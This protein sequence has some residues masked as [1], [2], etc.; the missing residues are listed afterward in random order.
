M[1]GRFGSGA[2]PDSSLRT[3][4]QPSSAK[5]GAGR[6]IRMPNTP[7]KLRT[8]R[9]GL[10]ATKG[11]VGEIKAETKGDAYPGPSNPKRNGQPFLRHLRRAPETMDGPEETG[12]RSSV[13]ESIF[14]V[15]GGPSPSVL[16]HP[17]HYYL[18]ERIYGGHP[19][20]H[21]RSGKDF[22][23]RLLVR[24]HRHPDPTREPLGD[25]GEVR[26]QDHLFEDLPH[27]Q[28]LLDEEFPRDLRVEGAEV[29]FVDEQR[30][31]ATERA[32]DLR[33]RREFPGDRES[34]GGVDLR[35]L[36]A[37]EFCDVV[38][39]S[40][41][42]LDEDADSVAPAL[43]VRL[44][45]DPTEPAVRELGQVLRRLDLE[46]RQELIDRVH[47]DAP[48]VEHAIHEDIVDLEFPAERLS[49]PLRVLQ[50]L[51][52]GF[53]TRNLFPQRRGLPLEEVPRLPLRIEF[54]LQGLDPRL[55]ATECLL[56]RSESRKFRFEGR[57]LG[58]ERVPLHREVREPRARLADLPQED[59]EFVEPLP[60]PGLFHD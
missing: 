24:G 10:A 39:L 57:S 44:Q 42:A 23:T 13:A 52:V 35:L 29:P 2:S 17:T 3:R 33:H 30:L 36:P 53:E 6:D 27:P 47:H 51:R 16:R 19:H 49:L 55:R 37:A 18:T 40:V 4:G 15:P 28:Q 7:A 34:K 8:N 9:F 46:F 26:D 54:S 20:L 48:L 59:R 58:L 50:F 56:R 43:L 22:R 32:A 41:D 5:E 25:L 21:C 45:A 11:G 38:P 14:P 12:R 1:R 60:L 31:H